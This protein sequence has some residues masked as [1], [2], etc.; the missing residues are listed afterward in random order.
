MLVQGIKTWAK[1]IQLNPTIAVQATATGTVSKNYAKYTRTTGQTG[2][3]SNGTVVVCNTLE[4]SSGTA[5]AVNTGTG[6]V[7]LAAGTYRLRGMVPGFTTNAINTRPSFMWYNETASAYVGT[8]SEVYTPSDGAG[9]GAF[10]GP[11]EAVITVATTTVV[12]FRLQGGSSGV[13]SIGG[14]S[15]F[16][17]AGSYPWIDIEQMGAAFALNTLDTISTTGNVTVGGNLTATGGIRKSARVLTTTTTLTVADASGFIE[18]AGS[19]T[20]TV[21]LP[22]PTQAA[23]SGIGY[24]FWQ[25]TSQNITLSTPVGAFY[26]PSGSAA[27]T[28]VLAQATTQ[29]WDVWS[30]GYNWTVFG[31]KTV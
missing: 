21:T 28:K 13:V 16:A 7:T 15:D 25:N 23:N 18:F 29:Y 1:V 3:L 5:I 8:S 17:A 30:D 4:N 6:Q 12:S 31:I 10:G 14:N 19:G 2:S 24:R 22:D 27:S 20:Y 11:A 26:G 9:Y